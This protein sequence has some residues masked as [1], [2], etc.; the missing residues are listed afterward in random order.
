MLIVLVFFPR[1]LIAWLITHGALFQ[2]REIGFI[3]GNR[4]RGRIVPDLL[5]LL[6]AFRAIFISTNTNWS[7]AFATETRHLVNAF[8]GTDTH[9]QVKSCFITLTDQTSFFHYSK[10][11]HCH[12]LIY[13]YEDRRQ[14]I[15]RLK[16]TLSINQECVKSTQTKTACQPNHA[17]IITSSS[18]TIPLMKLFEP[19]QT[20]YH[21]LV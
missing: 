3:T 18:N 6:F 4:G 19:K 10:Y 12:R 13:N 11:C 7:I 8:A 5:L 15:I 1:H 14:N 16:Q 20:S 2:M 21:F 17:T 9:E